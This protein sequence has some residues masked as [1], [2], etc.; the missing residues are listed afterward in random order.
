MAKSKGLALDQLTF[1]FD[2]VEEDL[3]PLTGRVVCVLGSFN[4]NMSIIQDFFQKK[5]AEFRPGAKPNRNT[6]YVLMGEQPPVQYVEYMQTMAFHGFCPRVL[7]QSDMDALLSG[8][9]INRYLVPK[10]IRKNLK[11]S[12][13]HY[14]LSRVDFSKRMNPLYTHEL[15]VAS[16]THIPTEQ[17]YLLLGSRGVYANNYIDDSTDTILLSDA[18]IERLRRGDTDDTIQYIEKTYN[19]S[20]SQYFRYSILSESDVLAAFS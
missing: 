16:D 9:D 4:Q 5:G 19:N 14:E 10:D 8:E 18:C 12:Y 13:Q 6:H 11:L 1:S 20:K 7:Y 2:E 15:F 3:Y 17:L